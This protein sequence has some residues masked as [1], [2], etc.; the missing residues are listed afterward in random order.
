VLIGS[1]LSTDCTAVGAAG[2]GQSC[3]VNGAADCA[4]GHVCVDVQGSGGAVSSR[5]RRACRVGVVNDC[6]GLGGYTCQAPSNV[7]GAFW[8]F[9]CST[10][11]C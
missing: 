6:A 10:M 11:G 3:D 9:C 2:D 1:K 5:C 4:P 7:P 8:G